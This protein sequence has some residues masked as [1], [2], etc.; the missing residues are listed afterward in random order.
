MA[1]PYT[2]SFLIIVNF[3]SNDVVGEISVQI[4]F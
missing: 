3:E 4:D 1:A 2:K